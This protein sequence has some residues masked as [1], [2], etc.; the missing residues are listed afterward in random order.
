MVYC[1]FYVLRVRYKIGNKNLEAI[2]HRE[3]KVSILRFNED[4]TL[5]S[6][7]AYLADS[8]DIYVNEQQSSWLRDVVFWST[9]QILDFLVIRSLKL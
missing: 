8:H 7:A 5:S 4:V 6:V 2:D 9:G 3:W 1:D